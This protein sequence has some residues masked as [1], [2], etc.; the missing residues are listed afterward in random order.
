VSRLR[1]FPVLAIIALTSL[2]GVAVAA[3]S[4]PG[5]KTEKDRAAWRAIV[6]WPKSCET[7]WKTGHLPISGIQTWKAPDG[8]TLVGVTCFEG[9]YQGST[10]LYLVDAAKKSG[11]PQRLHI[12]EDPGSGKP[13]LMRDTTILGDLSY[14]PAHARLTVF[15]K[16]RGPADCGIYSTFRLTGGVFVPTTVHAKTACNGKPPYDPQKWPRL[17]VPAQ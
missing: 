2:A 9:A 13:T 14:E 11:G 15:D 12:Y 17:H 16:F 10:M 7:S 1:L 3:T 6:K 4:L 8:R 5:T